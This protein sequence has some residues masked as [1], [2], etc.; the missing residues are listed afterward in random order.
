VAE[1]PCTVLDVMAHARQIELALLYTASDAK[2]HQSS[3]KEVD[4]PVF[5]LSFPVRH[6]YLQIWR[7]KNGVLM[8]PNSLP[9]KFWNLSFADNIFRCVTL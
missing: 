6:F 8:E 1:S 2:P 7:L 4:L 9:G 5:A 3:V